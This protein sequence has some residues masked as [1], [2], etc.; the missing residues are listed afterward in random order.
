MQATGCALHLKSMKVF[1]G[2]DKFGFDLLDS[3]MLTYLIFIE[4][5]NRF[6]Q[7]HLGA[8]STVVGV[9]PRSLVGAQFMFIQMP[10]AM[11]LVM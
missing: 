2:Q 10:R 7:L 3:L 4:S 6:Q 1:A 9:V 11:C 5:R 8:E